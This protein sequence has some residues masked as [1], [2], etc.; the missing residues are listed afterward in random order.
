MANMWQDF[1]F[2]NKEMLILAKDILFSANFSFKNGKLRR[3]TRE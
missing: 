3:D 2:C 1:Q